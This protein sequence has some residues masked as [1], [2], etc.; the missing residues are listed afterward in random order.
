MA[1]PVRFPNAGQ[2]PARLAEIRLGQE[3]RVDLVPL[4]S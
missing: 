2:L 3:T 4:Q 1:L